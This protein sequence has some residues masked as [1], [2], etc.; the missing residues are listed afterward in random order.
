MGVVL[1]FHHA[2]EEHCEKGKATAGDYNNYAW[3]GLFDDKVDADSVKNAQQ[4]TMMTNN[5][6][7]PEL[8]TLA[9]IY[10]HQGNTAEA[11]DELLKA[12]AVATLSEPNSE[13]WYGFGSI[14]EQYGVNDAA[15]EAFKKVERPEGRIGTASTY[16][17]AQSRL[18][19]LE[20]ALK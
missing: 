14:Y 7:F 16:A 10:A 1:G 18:K 2:L 15:I 3:L 17:L 9:C 19:D 12:M 13:A 8:H 5:G 11:R 6:T 20:S 4:A